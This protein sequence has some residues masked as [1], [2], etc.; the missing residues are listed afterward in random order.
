MAVFKRLFQAGQRKRLGITK[1]ATLDVLL[2]MD[3]D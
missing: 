3:A 2:Q 1:D